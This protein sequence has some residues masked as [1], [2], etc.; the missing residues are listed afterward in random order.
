[1]S[2]L[3]L[4]RTLHSNGWQVIAANPVDKVPAHPWKHG[5]LDA[6]GIEQHFANDNRL[7][8]IVTGAAAR[9]FVVDC[10]VKDAKNG[11]A[12]FAAHGTIP[13]T[14][15]VQT[16]SGGRHYYFRHP[17]DGDHVTTTQSP[18]GIDVRGDG[19]YVVAAGNPGYEV[20]DA[21]PVAAAPDWLLARVVRVVRVELPGV[22]FTTAVREDLPG[23]LETAKALLAVLP[24]ESVGYDEWFRVMGALHFESGG[25]Q[26][27]FD[28]F[29]T[30][31]GGD[32]REGQYQG[33]HANLKKWQSFSADA[34]R[35][36]RFGTIRNM[37]KQLPD[38]KRALAELG[39]R[40]AV[41]NMSTATTGDYAPAGMSSQLPGLNGEI[42]PPQDFSEV[43]TIPE[44]VEKFRGCVYVRSEHRALLPTGELLRPEQFKA[45]FG[46][47]IF[48]MS[49]DC[50]QPSKNAWEAFTENR[51]H[52]FPQVAKLAF[53]PSRPF[54]EIDDNAVNTYLPVDFGSPEGGEI[55]TPLRFYAN[56]LPD[57][58]ERDRHL[59]WVANKV[60]N[61]H[62]RQFGV[63]L[64]AQDDHGTGRGLHFT[65]LEKLVGAQYTRRI[66]YRQLASSEGQGQFEDWQFQS[67]LVYVEEARNIAR[68][69]AGKVDEFEILKDNVD[70]S[71][72]RVLTITRK[73]KEAAKSRVFYS[74]ILATNHYDAIWL[75]PDD[76]RFD[77]LSNG[78]KPSNELAKAFAEWMKE[79]CN[80]AAWVEYLNGIDL[81]DFDS[82]SAPPLSAAKAAMIDGAR[83]DLDRAIGDALAEWPNEIFT[84]DQIVQAVSG[85]RAFNA[86]IT[87]DDGWERAAR[88]MLRRYPVVRGQL[89][90]HDGRIRVTDEKPMMPG[91][92]SPTRLVTVLAKTKDAAIKWR[93][94]DTAIIRK[95]IGI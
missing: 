67:T 35:A 39:Q 85:G 59:K 71:S 86:D 10:D 90:G 25:A 65:L 73:G 33:R 54:G 31:S 37:I 83:S 48:I 63:I 45:A 43:L 81:S 3:E 13:P 46:G 69:Q 38:G 27:A 62:L 78:E 61:P 87:L 91:M 22:T 20:I 50:S 93:S 57:M 8:G 68:T 94:Y 51:A 79:P 70:P 58:V 1:M 4:A 23:T 84:I 92:K 28:I 21:S 89:N 77:V 72:D 30:W 34:S 56:F 52:R 42:L 6:A 9:V 53:D 19:G 14:F 5:A 11:V 88:K 16:R 24:V 15:T 36:V 26:E 7:V 60:R 55:E 12:A 82:Y 64:V 41:R 49:P 66:K 74:T 95:V 76:R 32:T 29:D 18:D 40:E 17:G 47:H 80:V 75:H 44:Q 2:A